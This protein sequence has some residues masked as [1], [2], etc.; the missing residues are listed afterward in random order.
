MPFEILDQRNAVAS[1]HFLGDTHFPAERQVGFRKL[2]TM[3]DTQVRL[4]GNDLSCQHASSAASQ[5]EEELFKSMEEVEAQTI[6][7]L[8][9]DEDDLFSGVI[10][11]LGL[12]AHANKGDESED[13]DLFSSGGGMELKED[14]RISMVPRN[15]DIVRVLNGQGRSSNG[16]IVGEHPSRTLFVRNID[17]YVED[18]EL[19]ALFEENQ[20]EKDVNQR[21]VV[22][23]NL[24]SS[25]STDELQ[26]IFC[27][28][29]EIKEI[30]EIPHKHD[31]KFIEFYDVKAAEAAVH[32]MNRNDI[33]GKLFKLE[34][35]RLWGVRSFMQ[36]PELEQDEPNPCKST[37]DELSSGNSVASGKT[38]SGSMGD[39]STQVVAP[40]ANQGVPNF[41]P[42]SLSKCHDC[43]ANGIPFNSY[44]TIAVTS[45]M[46][47]EGLDNRHIRG[48]KSNGHLSQ[49]NARVFGSPGNGSLPLNGNHYMWNNSHS[50]QHDLPSAMVLPNSP[51][52]VNGIHANHLPCV[53]AFPRAPPV[54]LNVGS[55]VHHHIGSAPPVN[56][57]FWDRRHPYTGESP[58]ASGFHLGSLGSMGFPSSLLSHPS[59]FASRN[60]FSHAGGNCMDL[61]KNG[62]V[63]SSQQM[64]H[65]FPGRNP[66]DCVRSFSYRRNESN[67][68]SAD[69]KQFEL[70]IDR[71]IR[72][73]D[74]RTTLMIKN[75]PNKYTSKMLLA[76]IDEHCRGT[77][78]F[79]Y[80]PI[81]FK[82]KCNVGYA[83]INMIDPQ[84]IIPLYKAFNGKKWEK[85]NSEKVA[86][87]AYAR[88]Q[89]KAALI[90]HFQNS[91]LMN[92]DKRCRPILFHTS[93]PNAGD[94]EPFPM[95]TNIRPRP[96]R[97]RTTGNDEKHQQGI[98]ST[99]VNTEEFSNGADSLLGFSK[100]SD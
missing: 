9:P 31:H 62:G 72:G 50:H 99:L 5:H 27:A 4:L 6:G 29:G 51:S 87:I 53:P 73:E 86:S 8:L 75:I 91:S 47:A 80:L 97:P 65:L 37:F 45:P 2:K 84:Q 70:D 46:M 42:H 57:A 58:E 77:Y 33:A 68:S 21:T 54:M 15:S 36:Q 85:F 78:D 30:R 81:D 60:I 17:C 90:T 10:G 48:A 13:F 28:F 79:I 55:P 32:A 66:N 34:P 26:Q 59:E 19:K 64:S 3:S 35:R 95:G 88:I 41:H 43:L 12:N 93:G 7:N 69:K 18:S 83:F 71:I 40:F 92:E 11:D 1:S 52:F 20:S 22:V 96:R 49:P 24:D 16:L 61:T 39:G 23:F 38:A 14:D 89:G 74:S 100:D 67:S 44:S 63:H 25:V 98:S 82:N 76:A 56:S 94:Q